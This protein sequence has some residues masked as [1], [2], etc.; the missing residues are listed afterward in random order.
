MQTLCHDSGQP[1]TL[2]IGFCLATLPLLTHSDTSKYGLHRIPN[3]ELSFPEDHLNFYQEQEDDEDSP[4]FN[5][6]VVDDGEK[7][8]THFDDEKAPVASEDTPLLSNLLN[9]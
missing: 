9:V 7:Q 3:E 5:N 1:V 6:V 8:E 4:V 2:A